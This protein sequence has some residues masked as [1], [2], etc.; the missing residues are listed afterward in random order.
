MFFIHG[1][2]LAVDGDRPLALFQRAGTLEV[3]RASGSPLQWLSQQ[4]GRS[5][6]RGLASNIMVYNCKD[7][8]VRG[9]ASFLAISLRMCSRMPAGET[10]KRTPNVHP[11]CMR[12]RAQAGHADWF[13]HWLH[14]FAS[15]L[16]HNSTLNHTALPCTQIELEYHS[17]DP[18]KCVSSSPGLA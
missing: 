11:S 2:H 18:N 3:T 6:V 7:C 14:S 12:A 9:P 1:S 10:K 17:T 13:A 16:L 5:D 4:T 15:Q 8:Q